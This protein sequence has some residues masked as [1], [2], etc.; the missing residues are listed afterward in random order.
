MLMANI[1]QLQLC[2]HLNAIFAVVIVAF[3]LVQGQDHFT[4]TQWNPGTVVLHT[5]PF[6]KWSAI[7]VISYKN[8]FWV[9]RLWEV[10][11]QHDACFSV[12]SS[13]RR[14]IQCLIT[15]PLDVFNHCNVVLT[16]NTLHYFFPPKYYQQNTRRRHCWYLCCYVFPF[17][18]SDWGEKSN[19]IKKWTHYILLVVRLYSK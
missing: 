13:L 4:Y 19:I 10:H 5:V 7:L 17:K 12:F 6:N 15:F 8:N 16:S 3:H 1:N 11:L 2:L 9:A 18:N 14:P